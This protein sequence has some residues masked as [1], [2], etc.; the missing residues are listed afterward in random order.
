M[1]SK[2]NGVSLSDSYP[3]NS[4]LEL[5]LSPNG[6]VVKGLVYCTD[7]ISNSIVIKKSL[8]YT[9]LAS[10]YRI[11][12]ASS[13]KTKKIIAAEAPKSKV[14]EEGKPI[15]GN[16]GSDVMEVFLPLPNVSKKNIEEREKRALYL[17]QEGMKH[18]NQKATPEG[19]QVFDR[20][21]KACNEVKWAGESIIVLGNIKVDPP[22]KSENC[23]LLKSGGVKH[24][25]SLDRVKR[26]VGA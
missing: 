21:L 9:T 19:Q 14:D 5:T 26:I 11:I 23:L 2:N 7:E 20:L 24:E 16:D 8:E 13:V 3:A 4:I 1:S 22:Y 6:E 10:E 12:N 17:A 15:L 25:G 18:I